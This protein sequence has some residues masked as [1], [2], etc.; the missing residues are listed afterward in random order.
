L[1]EVLGGRDGYG[2]G[3]GGEVLMPS[4]CQSQ[5]WSPSQMLPRFAGNVY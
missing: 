3:L 2:S 5:K 1:G 4:I